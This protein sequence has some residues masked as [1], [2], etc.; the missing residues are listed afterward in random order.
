M[1]RRKFLTDCLAGAGS[2]AIAASWVESSAKARTETGRHNIQYVRDKISEFQITPYRGERYED[3]VPD[4]LDIA[5]RS[6]LAIHA[7]TSITDAEADDEIF[8]F[9]DIFRNPVIASHD[10]S[11]RVQMCEGF[12]ESL[13]LLR[14]ATGSS[15]NDHVDSTWMKV[16]LKSLGPDGLY[17]I[18]LNGRPW[19]RYLYHVGNLS[20]T[21]PV[22]RAD[23]STTDF[24]DKSV[25]QMTT[26]E[27]CARALLTIAV[28]Y[29][30][31]GNAMWKDAGKRRVDRLC[32]IAVRQDD[33]A[34]VSGAWEPNARVGRDAE[35]PLAFI[36]EEWDGRLIQG[37][38]Q[39]YKIT[40]Y[41]PALELA[42]RI[43]KF[44]RYHSRYYDGEGRFLFDESGTG[45][46]RARARASHRLAGHARLRNSRQRP[47]DYGVHSDQL[48]VDQETELAFRCLHPGRV[49]P[50]MV[51][52]SL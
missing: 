37:L 43:T 17:Y 4:T 23:G 50:R 9:V 22:W 14:I 11:D 1:D 45:G 19:S 35:M 6:K 39:N 49:V 36:A 51:C 21:D 38:A 40:G 25:A 46:W 44:Y 27:V 15:L 32:E 31:D 16:A 33:Y 26:G 30:R 24:L 47:R 13:P 7:L 12:M 28:Y 5:E 41:E 3:S 34:Y 18:P 10:M 42:G 8:W 48:R 2:S 20:E 29:L 52:A